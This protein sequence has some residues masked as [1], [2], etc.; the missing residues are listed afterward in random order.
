MTTPSV[1]RVKPVCVKTRSPASYSLESVAQV[2]CGSE[3]WRL[4]LP[5]S[6]K[7]LFCF[8]QTRY[9]LGRLLRHE[10]KKTTCLSQYLPEII[11]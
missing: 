4:L 9:N 8:W 2:R 11:S 10:H 6:Q 7:A 3:R 5:R 1:Q